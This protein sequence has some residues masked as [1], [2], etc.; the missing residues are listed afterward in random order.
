MGDNMKDFLIVCDD[1]WDKDLANF[2][3]LIDPEDIVIFGD[4]LENN[5]GTKVIGSVFRR[6][7]FAER[8]I[9]ED[10]Y[11]R[12]SLIQ[13][14]YMTGSILETVNFPDNDSAELWFKLEYRG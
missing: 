8:Y 5:W 1:K 13:R 2:I 10:S 12:T 14:D 11:L 4:I 6:A 7:G 3:I 9:T